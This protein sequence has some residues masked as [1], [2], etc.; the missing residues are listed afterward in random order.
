MPPQGNE[1]LEDLSRGRQN[2]EAG[3]PRSWIYTNRNISA[4]RKQRCIGA[5]DLERLIKVVPKL[6]GQGF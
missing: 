4:K 2:G 1:R 5:G 3:K 6:V